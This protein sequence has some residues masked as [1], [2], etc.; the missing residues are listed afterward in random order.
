MEKLMAPD[1]TVSTRSKTT[2]PNIAKM[3]A[4]R[5]VP[6]DPSRLLPLA[7]YINE[8]LDRITNRGGR[9]IFVRLPTFGIV[10]EVEEHYFPKNVYWDQL[11]RTVNAS[12]IHYQ[13]YP[14]LQNFDS[15]D[16]SHIDSRE[17]RRFTPALAKFIKQH[18]K[19]SVARQVFLPRS[20]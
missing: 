18:L 10:A 5:V 9:V 13:N 6:I 3:Y 2:A 20:N 16:S 17:S 11:A 12:F 19:K 15:Q 4:N 7:E 14:A 1:R 8:M